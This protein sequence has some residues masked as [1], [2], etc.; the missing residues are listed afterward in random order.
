M[1]SLKALTT[2]LVTLGYV[3][4]SLPA[5]AELS[6]AT[7]INGVYTGIAHLHGYKA[8]PKVIWNV[9]Q[10]KLGGCGRIYGSQYCSRNHTIYITNQDIRMAYRYG[11]A[12]LAYIVA[13]EYAHAMQIAYRFK[14]RAT[15]VYELQA[16][17]L[18]GVYMG[19][20]PNIVFDN[21]DIKEISALAYHIGDY[22][23]GSQ[24]HG[25]PQQRMIAVQI[26]LQASQNGK[27]LN[28]CKIR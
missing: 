8:T 21:R 12:A 2:A 24:H 4:A 25:T 18:A 5:K 10:G 7:V 16:D 15:P 11:D 27:G 3:L 23:W 1:K 19:L 26:G 6:A 9:A 20:I 28:A 13:H 17:C 22:H 14:P